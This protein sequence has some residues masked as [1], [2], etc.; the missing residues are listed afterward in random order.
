MK[1]A[2]S[3]RCAVLHT[4]EYTGAIKE[5]RLNGCLEEDHLY[6]SRETGFPHTS[7]AI[8]GPPCQRLPPLKV[9]E[10]ADLYQSIASCCLER[11]MVQGYVISEDLSFLC[12]QPEAH[13]VTVK[14]CVLFSI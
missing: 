14:C 11:W 3:G 1:H 10:A 6:V 9:L 7:H 5:Y 8:Q 2:R 4:A 13:P 12:I